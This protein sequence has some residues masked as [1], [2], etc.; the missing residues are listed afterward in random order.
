[1][2]LIKIYFNNTSVYFKLK[3]RTCKENKSK[4]LVFLALKYIFTPL[5]HLLGSRY[6]KLLFIQRENIFLF[7]ML[8]RMLR[9]KASEMAQQAKR[10]LLI[11]PDDELNPQNPE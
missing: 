4:V 9:M 8:Y 7:Q 1:M 3:N 5:L 11:Q 6:I 10:H 2:E